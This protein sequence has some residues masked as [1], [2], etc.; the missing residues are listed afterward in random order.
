MKRVF[1]IFFIAILFINFSCKKEKSQPIG[2]KTEVKVWKP[3]DT[4]SL[5]GVTAKRG[6]ITKTEKASEGY[7]LFEPTSSTKSFLIDMDGNIVHKWDSDLSSNHAYLLDNGHLLKLEVI[8]DPKTFAFGGMVG[9]LREYDW[10]GNVVWEFDYADENN[11]MNHDIEVLPNG[12]ILAIAYE[13]ISQKDAIA[14]GRDPE[15]VTSA[16]LWVDKIIEIKPTKPIGGEIVWEWRMMDHLIQDFDSTK[17]NYGVVSENPRRLDINI[18]SSHDIPYM[19]KDQFVI[20]LK[21]GMGMKNSTF[22]N[23]HAEV[24]HGNAISYNADLDQIVFS[25]KY[26]NEI[27]ILDHSTTTEEAKG[28]TGGKWGHGGDLLYRWGNQENYGKGTKEDKKL[29][30]QHDVKFIP[31]GFPGEGDLILFNNDIPDPNSKY[32]NTFEALMNIKPSP[33]VIV[34]IEELGNYSA[35]YEFSPPVNDDG[36]YTITDEGTFGP[37]EPSWIYMAPDKRSMYSPFVSG[38]QRLKNGN[39]LI[40]QGANGRFLEVTP[41][42]EIVWEYWNPYYYD[43]KLPDG[44]NPAPS[45]PF[46]FYQFRATFFDKE[47][48]AFKG[49]DLK[50]ISP[51]PEPFVLKMPPPPTMEKDSVQ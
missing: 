15:N 40:T 5:T 12:N 13:V 49:K 11:I 36:S 4:R 24:T 37:S 7:V 1:T 27:Y 44:T 33:E 25:F 19:D 34:S 6:L 51:Q 2:E 41:N 28:N 9:K 18:H 26:F 8:D 38:V 43:Y 31:N 22:E 17:P 3:E 39:T 42:K 30:V 32:S 23:Q 48:P 47:F 50:P 46:I 14:A 45:G 29:F 35:V 21:N 10:D 16:G 20:S